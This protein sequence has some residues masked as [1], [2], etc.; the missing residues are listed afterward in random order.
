M[1]D[2]AS[3]MTDVTSPMEEGQVVA[4]GYLID[5]GEDDH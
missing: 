3:P 4:S 1:T 2:V 5:M